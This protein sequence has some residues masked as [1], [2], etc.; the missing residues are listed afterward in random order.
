VK[1]SINS[2]TQCQKD[3]HKIWYEVLFSQ[4]L[5]RFIHAELRVVLGQSSQFHAETPQMV[6][7]PGELFVT[8]I[9]PGLLQ[10]DAFAIRSLTQ[11]LVLLL[12]DKFD[13]SKPR[14]YNATSSNH[15]F[16]QGATACLLRFNSL[17]TSRKNV[18]T[19]FANG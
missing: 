14:P 15:I 4:Q 16:W 18:S 19:G 13:R 3:G 2:Q 11:D 12:S 17:R 6:E 10:Q 1:I 9:S 7:N 8:T 5:S